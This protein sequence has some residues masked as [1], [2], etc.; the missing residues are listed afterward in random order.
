MVAVLLAAAVTPLSF[1]ALFAPG[2]PLRP[3]PRVE[4]LS[5]KRVRIEGFMARMEVPPRGAFWLCKAPL[6][7]DEAGG[8]TADLPV[9][10]ILVVLTPRRDEPVPALRGRL[11]VLGRLETGRA[12]AADGTVSFFRIVL[13]AHRFRS[14]RNQ[15]NR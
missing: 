8:G 3:S 4:E 12:V 5:G 7:L 6:E 13:D 9:E 15:E 2:A 1:S 10:S 11:R 14:V